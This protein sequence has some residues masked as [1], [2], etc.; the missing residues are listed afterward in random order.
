MSSDSGCSETPKWRVGLGMMGAE[1]EGREDA[2]NPLIG[3]ES[4]VG[5][6]E[7]RGVPV[8]GRH[9][10]KFGGI[11][12]SVEL[13]VWL[14]LDVLQR[15][16]SWTV[17]AAW[18]EPWSSCLLCDSVDM[19]ITKTVFVLENTAFCATAAKITRAASSRLVNR[20]DEDAGAWLFRS[21]SSRSGGFVLLSGGLQATL[22]LGGL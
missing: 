3:P 7:G 8:L 20:P 2:W 1:V 22:S 11:C 15:R 16:G 12:G 21:S 4:G 14:A 19:K 6:F 9:R 18:I 17:I 10:G 5:R 13:T